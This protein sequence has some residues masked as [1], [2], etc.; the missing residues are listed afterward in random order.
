LA[1]ADFQNQQVGSGQ[2]SKALGEAPRNLISNRRKGFELAGFKK[3]FANLKA[4]R[5]KRLR[6]H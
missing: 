6:I 4:F 3:P 1:L 5:A 2:L